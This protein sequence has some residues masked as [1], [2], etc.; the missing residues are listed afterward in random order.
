ML[1]EPQYTKI[2]L[3][4]IKKSSKDYY[5]NLG[6]NILEN[7][8]T[9]DI[10]DLLQNSSNK[11][12]VKCDY[13]NEEYLMNYN[14]YIASIKNIN[15]NACSSCKKYKDKDI[16]NFKKKSGKI[17][18]KEKIVKIPKRKAKRNVN[19][20]FILQTCNLNEY[21]LINEPS[22]KINS[23]STIKFI[24][25]KHQINGVQNN[26]WTRISNKTACFYCG[27]EKRTGENSCFWKGGITPLSIYL[28]LH[29]IE[30]KIDSLK[31]N[32]YKCIL[33]GSSKNIIIH[34]LY[35]NFSDIVFETLQILKLP[36]Y[37]KI[38]KYTEEE[39]FLIQD[40]CLKLHYSYGLGIVLDKSLHKQFHAIYGVKNNTVEQF[41]E[42]RNNYFKNNE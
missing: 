27:I 25:K 3:S 40:M 19:Y 29:I 32:N 37:K 16:W 8:I 36:I 28:R 11:V 38:N 34:H 12:L 21:I 7:I 18:I 23:N 15:K 22:E 31:N 9:I 6:Y 24:C 4:K 33:T 35:K 42:F 1:I 41:N 10:K 5:G 26:N 39:L 30:W 17:N 2:N 20:D 14:K 13:C